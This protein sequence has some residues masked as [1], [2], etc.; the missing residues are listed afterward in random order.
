M[1]NTKYICY[2]CDNYNTI[3]FYEIKN[4][5]LRKIPCNKR[6][7]II[8]LSEDQIL[9]STLMPYYNNIHSIENKDIEY[10]EKSNL[11]NKN[12]YELFEEITYIEKN[13][14]KKCKYC[15]ENFELIS[16]LKKHIIIKCFYKEIIKR[17]I[18]N[19]NNK[20]INIS[21]NTIDSNN[22]TNIN[23][24]NCDINNINLYLQLKTPI[25][26]EESWDLS[27][28]SNE[29]Q[30]FIMMSE[31]MYT[32]LLEAILENDLN[33]NVIIDSDK[34][35]GSVYMN[36]NDKYISMKV[37]NIVE[38]SMEKLNEHL[39]II[40]KN[41]KSTQLKD[42]IRYSR[43]IFNKKFIDYKKD[44]DLQKGVNFVM[45]NIFETKIENAKKL[46]E[47][48]VKIEEFNKNNKIE[49]ND[50]T[51]YS[52]EDYELENNTNNEKKGY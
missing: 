50:E 16:E 15:N 4:H 8:L 46:A 22:T 7:D 43:Q 21:N 33:N 31:Y 51:Y 3:R 41:N 49:N 34:K 45:S 11:I 6:K 5:I 29:K 48:V 17:N 14:S 20:N 42:T 24:N 1:P 36:H 39:N 27:Q 19:E 44:K 9:I 26:F 35:S 13:K 47:N 10:L 12:K 2:R 40:N 18:D 38:K 37:K 30:F 23:Y 32:H 25:P 28:I 52:D